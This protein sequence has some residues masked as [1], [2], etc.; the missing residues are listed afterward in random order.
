MTPLTVDLPGIP[1]FW[2]K[3]RSNTNNRFLGLDDDGTLAPFAID[4]MQANSISPNPH[5][6]CMGK[7]SVL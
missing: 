6:R 1:N 5:Y 3:V 7:R 2:G 4:P